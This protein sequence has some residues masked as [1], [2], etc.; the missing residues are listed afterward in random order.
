MPRLLYGLV[1]EFEDAHHVVE[2][3]RK[4][5][6]AGYRKVAAYSPV[7]VEGLSEALGHRDMLVP[8]IMLAGGIAGGLGG[9][10]LLTWTTAF[11]YPLNIGGRP[12]FAWPSFIPITFECTVLLSALSGIAG[13]FAVNGLPQPY[14]PVFDTPHFERATSDRFFLSVEATDPKFDLGETRRLLEGLDPLNV[15]EVEL[16]K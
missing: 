2:A 6:D 5:R 7:P 1:A 14:H 9:F 3:A 15:S 10:A 13:M 4:V 8:W 11:A 16:R 12:L